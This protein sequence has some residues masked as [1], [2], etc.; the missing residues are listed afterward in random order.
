[1][2]ALVYCPFPDREAARAAANTLLDRKL[3]ACANLLGEVESIYSWNGERGDS[4]EIGALFKTS[5]ALLDDAIQC[6]AE[7]HP[8]DT[9]AIMGWRCDS[10]SEATAAW[11]GELGPVDKLDSQ[12]RRDVIQDSFCGG[13]LGAVADGGCG[14]GIL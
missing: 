10:V 3:I 14:V 9:P 8:Y 6:L 12:S 7:I 5:A 4:F 2:S 11:L 13:Y 1:M